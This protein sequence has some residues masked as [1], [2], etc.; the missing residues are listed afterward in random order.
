[1]QKQCEKAYWDKT[2]QKRQELAV[3]RWSEVKAGSIS[4]NNLLMKLM[5][6]AEKKHKNWCGVCGPRTVKKLQLELSKHQKRK[7]DL[8]SRLT[9]IR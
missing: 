2:K 7:R 9:R 1:M 5:A 3:K 8:F 6:I 4:E